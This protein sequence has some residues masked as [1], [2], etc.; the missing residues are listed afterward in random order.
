MTEAKI[1]AKHMII[2]N[3]MLV[4]R[5]SKDWAIWSCQQEINQAL[6]ESIVESVCVESV[7]SSATT[8]NEV[9]ALVAMQEIPDS[10]LDKLV[11]NNWNG[12]KLGE[13]FDNAPFDSLSELCMELKTLQV[14]FM[15]RLP[16]SARQELVPF[17][18]QL[19]Q[20]NRS[21]LLSLDL[22][23]FSDDVMHGKALLTKFYN[24]PIQRLQSLKL[25]WNSGWFNTTS[26]SASYDNDENSCIKLL[27]KC[28]AQLGC[29]EQLSL[30]ANDFN[31][32]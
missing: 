17:T 1:V 29:L 3:D 23:S 6:N 8:I 5:S 25:S 27:C 9:V 30:A 18:S 14:S 22:S 24:W 4:A 13:T 21:S 11:L 12:V 20:C 2:M 7:E 15:M 32:G 10:G 31:T 28:L 16:I 26:S 19:I